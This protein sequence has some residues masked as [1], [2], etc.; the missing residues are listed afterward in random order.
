MAEAE[1]TLTVCYHG[2][3]EVTACLKDAIGEGIGMKQRE[4]R[5]NSRN[6]EP[7]GGAADRGGA[8][9]AQGDAA[10]FAALDVLV[11]RGQRVLLV[12]DLGILSANLKLSDAALRTKHSQYIVDALGHILLGACGAHVWAQ[13]AL[14]VEDDAV[15]VRR[16]RGQVS[17]QQCERVFLWG[18]VELATVKVIAARLEGGFDGREPLLVGL[19]TAGRQPCTELDEAGIRVYGWH[20][21]PISP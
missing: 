3:A 1:Q 17:V 18:A 12:V 21:L 16:I 20:C 9:L 4:L 19:S 2:N 8:D 5:L 13:A 11:N 10:D 15:G 7:L 14:D 6:L